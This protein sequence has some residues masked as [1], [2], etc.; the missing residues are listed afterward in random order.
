MGCDIHAL[1]EA[2]ET[3]GRFAR[4]VCSGEPSLDR[5]YFIFGV[6]SGDC[7]RRRGDAKPIQ[8]GRGLPD[9]WDMSEAARALLTGDN[10]DLHSHGYVTLAEMKAADVG[11]GDVP[12]GTESWDELIAEVASHRPSAGTDNDVRLVFAFDN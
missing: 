3:S 12:F 5:N 7:G 4:W 9:K 1:I 2:R 11:S 8:S 6:L 10:P